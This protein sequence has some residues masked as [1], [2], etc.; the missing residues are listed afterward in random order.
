MHENVLKVKE[1]DGKSTIFMFIEGVKD[2]YKTLRRNVLTNYVTMI[3]K[4]YWYAEVEE[5]N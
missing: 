2:L 1:I 4:I 5:A 3:A